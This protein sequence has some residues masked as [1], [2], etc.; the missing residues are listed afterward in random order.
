MRSTWL[1][2]LGMLAMLTS[3]ASSAHPRQALVA[4]RAG[5]SVGAPNDGQLVDGERLRTGPHL[6]I[7]PA[8]AGRHAEW[9]HGVLIALLDGAARDVHLAFPDTVTSVGDISRHGGREL[10]HHHSHESG[11]DADVAFFLADA[12][13]AAVLQDDYLRIDTAGHTIHKGISFDDARNWVFVRSLLTS[14]Q[15]RVMAI[16]VAHWI[17]ERLLSYGSRVSPPNVVQRAAEVLMQPT[18]APPHDDHFHLRIACPSKTPQC[19]ELPR[20]R[21]EI[22]AAGGEHR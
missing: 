9:G 18:D 8:Y 1:A 22:A 10:P 5:V 16:F 15:G 3:S 20:P 11:R 7:L 2:A 4:H 6:R 21:S 13:G 14:A 12:R 17:R 19:I